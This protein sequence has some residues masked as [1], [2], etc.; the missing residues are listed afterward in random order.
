MERNPMKLPHPAV[1]ALFMLVVATAA[2]AADTRQKVELP[3]MMRDHMLANMRDHLLAVSEI[4]DALAKGA[5][6]R[7]ADIAENR[8]GMSSLKSHGASHMAPYMPEAM[9][10]IGTGMHRAAS[11]FAVAAQ[12]AAVTG[13]TRRALGSLA[14]VTRQCVACHAAYRVH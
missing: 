8:V 11:R 2:R 9:R 12:E 7:A 5:F 13:D 14:E 1:A 3:P 6:D 4:Q 10:D